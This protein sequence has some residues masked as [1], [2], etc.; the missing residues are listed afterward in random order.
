MWA[1]DAYNN[2]CSNT[3]GIVSSYKQ[4]SSYLRGRAID[5]YNRVD[6]IV[7]GG[8]VFDIAGGPPNM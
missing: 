2:H 8:Q 4:Y 3:F 5:S 7:V 6:D 1:N